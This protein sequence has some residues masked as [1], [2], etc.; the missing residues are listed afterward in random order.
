LTRNALSEVLRSVVLARTDHA[1]DL[2]RKNLEP[3]VT[4]TPA[5]G[6]DLAALSVEVLDAFKLATAPV[7]FT[8][9]RLSA[10]LDEIWVWTKVTDLGDVV[11]DA[12]FEGSNNW[13]V[14]GN[15][16]STGRPI[17]AS[18]PHR[19]HSLPSLRYLVHLT[20]PGARRDR[21]W[22]A[23]AS[24]SVH[25]HNGTI[26]FG[27]TIFGADQEDVYVYETA[28]GRFGGLPLRRRMGTYASH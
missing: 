12:A 17:L 20:A 1:T 11:Q 4:P 15:L 10:S 9:E 25:R 23:G 22:R 8:P 27:L 16:T 6:L 13:V 19:A 21:G 5:Q 7:T 26:A 14:H 2:L 24:G 3:A 18:D 28:P